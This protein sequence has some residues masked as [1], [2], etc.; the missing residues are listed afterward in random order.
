M[1]CV[2]QFLKSEESIKLENVRES[3]R[4]FIKYVNEKIITKEIRMVINLFM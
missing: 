2:F 1:H 3:E 4:K